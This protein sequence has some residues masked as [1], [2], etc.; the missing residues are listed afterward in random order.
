MLLAPQGGAECAGDCVV[1]PCLEF[2][3]ASEML[4]GPV[5]QNRPDQ[6]EEGVV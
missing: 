3:T 6:S 4:E 5:D 1:F 2:S